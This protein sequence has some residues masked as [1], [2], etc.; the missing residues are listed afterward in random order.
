M[1]DKRT[2]QKSKEVELAVPDEGFSDDFINSI[3]SICSQYDGLQSA[4]LVLKKEDDD[5]CFLFGFQFGETYQENDLLINNIM[6]DILDLFEEDMA[7]EGVC[8]GNNIQLKRA[9]EEITEAFFI[10]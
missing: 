3:K 4:Y 10:R 6:N 1:I 7:F 2:I 5:I 8:L 9:I